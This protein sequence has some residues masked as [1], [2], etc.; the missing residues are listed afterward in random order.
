MA[1]KSSPKLRL[2]DF[3]A[4][5]HADPANVGPTV[6]LSGYLG[7]GTEDGVVRVYPDAGLGHWYDVAEDDIVHAKSIEDSP[8]GGS[9]L[10]VKASAKLTPSVPSPPPAPDAGDA[11]QAQPVGQDAGLF[12]PMASAACQVGPT[13]WHTC[14]CPIGLTGWHTC[15]C[16]IGPTGWHTCACPI[17]QTGW[18]TCAC[19]IG[20]TGTQG[21]T[22]MP[23]C[24][25]T[26]TC[27]P[28]PLA[29]APAAGVAL[30]QTIQFAC[31]P[32]NT[33]ATLCTQ[34]GCVPPT[35]LLGCPATHTCPPTQLLGC[36][37]THT[38]PP[39]QMFPCGPQNTTATLC[40]QICPPLTHMLGCPPTHTCP[41]THMLGCPP[42]HTCPPTH[43][44]GCPATQTCPLQ[45][46]AQFAAA[47]P[48]VPQT[49]QFAC[50]PHN[51]TAT[52]C[53][54]V[55]CHPQNTAA[56]LC[57][58]AACPQTRLIGCPA[59]HTCPV[60][61]LLPCGPNNTTATL[62]TQI[63]CPQSHG[64]VCPGP[65][66]VDA[67]PTWICMTV[68]GPCLPITMGGCVPGY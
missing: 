27:P 9:H 40:T 18:H 28:L 25:N 20:P 19:P 62:C 65:S 4:A 17:G 14:A 42:T 38:C 51:T 11:A 22:H 12:N 61:H 24:P 68:A 55:A 49:I 48:A 46:G 53:T 15:A 7:K 41:P 1:A 67:C 43:M 57:T 63:G 50:G 36:P 47:A 23:G 52:L 37:A 59:T 29:A 30:P 13:G 44:L 26:S 66:A 3:V 5:V 45:Q 21:C 33:T 32:H 34:V 8:L 2:D 56:T 31:G 39:T 64:A 6:L 16:P 58:Y 60:S 54:Q 10:W 35:H